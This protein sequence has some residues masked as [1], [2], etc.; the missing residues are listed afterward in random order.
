[1]TPGNAYSETLICLLKRWFNQL[2]V[3]KY[4]HEKK[5]KIKMEYYKVLQLLEK[6]IKKNPFLKAESK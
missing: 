3:H 6:R 4:L 2:A 5:I 1:M